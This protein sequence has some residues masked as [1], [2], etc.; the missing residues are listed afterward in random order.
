MKRITSKILWSQLLKQCSIVT[1]LIT[2]LFLFFSSNN[3]YSQKEYYNWYFGFNAAI[4]FDTHNAEPQSLP[5]SAL[6]TLEGCS[7]ISDSNGKLLFYT[8]GMKVWNSK[9]DLMTIDTALFGHNS[10]TQSTLIVKK[11]GKNS[12]YYIFT[13]DAG[14]YIKS[15]DS[16]PHINKGLNYSIVDAGLNNGSGKI[17]SMNIPIHQPM[18]E[19]LTAVNHANGYDIW[20]IAHEWGS[21]V[22]YVMLLTNNGIEKINKIH[23]GEIIN[24]SDER[25]IGYLKASPTGDKLG[26]VSEGVDYFELFNFDNKNGLISSPIKI[27]TYSRF[28]NYGLEFSPS[29]DLLYISE[30]KNRTIHQYSITKHNADSIKFSEMLVFS[31]T[32]VHSLG[33]LQLAPNEK[34]YFA[35][36]K[37]KYVGVINFPDKTGDS[38]NPVKNAVYLGN[39]T[40]GTSSWGLPNMNQSA[41]KLSLKLLSFDVCDGQYLSIIPKTNIMFDEMTWNWTGPKN[42]TSTSRYVIFN[43]S[44]VDLSG[45]YKLTVRFRDYVVIDSVYINVF[46]QPKAKILGDSFICGELSVLLKSKF[47]EKGTKYEW[48]TGENSSEISIARS[49]TYILKVYNDF[50]CEDF[51]TLIVKGAVINAGFSDIYQGNTGDICAGELMTFNIRFSNYGIN[52][53]SIINAE[54]A[55]INSPV[56]I[57]NINEIISE[58]GGQSFKDINL[59]IQSNSLQIINDTLII[60]AQDENCMMNF[61]IPVNSKIITVTNISF[62]KLHKEPG[63][64][65]CFPLNSLVNCSDDVTQTSDFQTIVKFNA[66]YFYPEEIK[67]VELEDNYISD[68][69]RYLKLKGLNKTVSKNYT[70][71]AEICGTVLVGGDAVIPFIINS[72]NWSDTL[73]RVNT[74]DGSIK[75][76]SCVVQIRPIQYYKPTGIKV[77]QNPSSEIINIEFSSQTKGEYLLKLV[78]YTGQVIKT[79]SITKSDNHLSVTKIELNVNE[80]SNG[81]YYLLLTGENKFITTKIFILK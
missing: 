29:G 58:I 15:M 18:T 42:F 63:E 61:K 2:L 37:E 5:K 47:I 38:C 60:S 41:F 73:M 62:P 26:Y 50:G 30:Y 80:L 68:G 79:Q 23:T 14:D 70:E 6:K 72:F 7:S 78:D 13:V 53:L 75:V 59:S 19:K 36:N 35:L 31:D 17:I 66:E 74:E 54:I 39:Q 69:F 12:E 77:S 67:G 65:I 27:N 21:N 55:N 56:K 8:D 44:T 28:Y 25:T 76:V 81:V 71:L 57:N 33:A 52:P 24:G 51:D 49:G 11:P 16:N 10:S 48:S 46:P 20:I 45:L 4:T 43:K 1:L 3:L 22:F 34:I 9:N 32:L 40:D 64:I